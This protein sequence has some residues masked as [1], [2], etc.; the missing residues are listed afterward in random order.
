MILFE[1][2][3]FFFAAD[4]CSLSRIGELLPLMR[5]VLLDWMA[6]FCVKEFRFVKDY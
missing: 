5:L 2:L 3:P 6:A 4:N 1:A